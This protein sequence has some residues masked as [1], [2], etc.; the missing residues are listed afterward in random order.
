[1]IAKRTLRRISRRRFLQASGQ[2]MLLT[3]LAGSGLI[4]SARA[5]RAQALPTTNVRLLATD[6]FFSFPGRRRLDDSSTPF[7]EIW[8]TNGI[9]G[10]GFRAVQPSETDATVD[11]LLPKYKNHVTW[12]A[13]ILAVAK[14][15]ELYLT[16]TN[17][18]FELRPDLDD[19]HTIHWHGFDNPNSVFDGVPEVS[20]SVPPS[21]DFPYY[22]VAREEGTYMYHCHFED[23]EHVQMGMDGIVY[24]E[25][26][27]GNAYDDDGGLTA[28]DRQFTLLLNEIDQSPHDNLVNIQ[29]FIW[30]NYKADYWVINGRSWPDTI[31]RDQELAAYEGGD[32][33]NQPRPDQIPGDPSD[34]FDEVPDLP[35]EEYADLGFS[36]P[37]SSLIQVEEGE[38]ALLRISNL[39][40]EQ[41]A[42]QLLGPRMTVVG[43]DATFLGSQIYQTNSI[44]IGPGE[45]R[46]VLVTAPAYDPALPGDTD[47]EARPYNH[48]WLRN[49]NSQRLVNGNLHGEL[50]GQITQMWVYPTGA[51]PAQPG[52]NLT[53]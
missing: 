22:Y 39:G 20:I 27:N 19:S 6:N 49:R 41:Q 16:M 13:P 21:R 11:T 43:H 42:M 36:Q 1:M 37:V 29:E 15:S 8:G 48:Y 52:P 40:Y 46:D 33:V 26:A 9:F 47:A 18:G 24:I 38:T 7:A 23:T 30:S 12:P 35:P 31:V 3:S 17:L 44:Y 4:G 34:P 53:V 28:F 51:L 45:S 32:F 2:G 50:G 10:F 25:A 14:D 5:P